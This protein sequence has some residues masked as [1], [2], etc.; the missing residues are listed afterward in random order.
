M[1][2]AKYKNKQ[3]QSM[4]NK[5]SQLS[6]EDLKRFQKE[7]SVSKDEVKKLHKVWENY[8]IEESKDKPSGMSLEGFAKFCKDVGNDDGNVPTIFGFIN[9]SGDD[10]IQFDEW[11][12]FVLRAKNPSFE[13][14]AQLVID[15]YDEDNSGTVSREEVRKL[16]MAKA[17]IEGR[18][19][20][21]REAEIN[22]T[23]ENIFDF[24][25]TNNDGELSKDEL[26]AAARKDPSF[27]QAF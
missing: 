16:A 25:D 19:S 12:C 20:P 7:F 18:L 8:A 14:Y 26:I 5:G 15:L 9:T 23:I 10:R 4:G 2:H 6:K 17:R 1:G 11:I 3:R 21:E 24:A 13:D 27:A 22:S